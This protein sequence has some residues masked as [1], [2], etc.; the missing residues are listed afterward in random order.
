MSEVSDI[1]TI[2]LKEISSRELGIILKKALNHSSFKT[3]KE[4]AEKC[5]LNYSTVSGYFKGHRKPSKEKFETLA[6]VL[7]SNDE[8]MPEVKMVAERKIMYD[9]HLLKKK[10]LQAKEKAI[11]LYYLLMKV[12]IDYLEFFKDATKEERE[13]LKKTIPP[14][15]V[16]YF[17]SLLSSLYD[18]NHLQIW[19]TFQKEGQ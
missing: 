17:T 16:G 14:E 13:I 7:L 3:I 10:D 9:S 18:E 12:A 15:D 5:G 19:K 8:A 2:N 11:H 4:L 6:S 1:K